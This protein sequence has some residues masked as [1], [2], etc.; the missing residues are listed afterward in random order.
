SLVRR[1][2]LSTAVVLTLGVGIGA[3]TLAFAIVDGVLLR[4]LPFPSPEELVDVSRVHPK[5]YGPNPTAAQAGN[6][7]ATPAATFFDWERMATTLSSMGAYAPTAATLA[8]ADKAPERIQGASVTA[9]LFTALGVR[10]TVGRHLVPSDD[11]PGAPP[12]VVLSHG[13]WLRRFGGD[14]SAVGRSINLDGT[15]V[16]VVGVMPAGF[17]FPDDDSDFWLEL[18]DA[19]KAEPARNAGYLHAVGRLAPGVSLER[20]RAEM[21]AI[22]DALG[23]THQDESRF[24]TVL[25]P[26][27]ELMVADARPGLLLLLGAAAIVLLVGCAN[28][29]NLL[30]ARAAERRRELAVHAALGAGRARLARLLLSESVMLA[31]VGGL[32]GIGLAFAGIG[33]MV[34]AFPMALP[35]AAGIHMDVRVLAVALTAS[36]GVGL[37]LGL[38]PVVRS[39]RL[40][41]NAVLRD[42]GRGATGGGRTS[43]THGLLVASEVALAVV[44]LSTSGLFV[45]SYL[46][47]GQ[48]DR[49]FDA[50]D[51]LT[52]RISMPDDRRGSD[53]AV[54]AFFAELEEDLAAIPAVR[55][56]A[57]AGQM[58][59]SGCCSS[60][61]ATVEGVE[62]NVQ[63]S[64][65]TGRVDES[66]FRAMRIPILAGRGFL[67]TDQ[68]GSA[69]V[70]VVSE[71]MARRFWRGEDPIG[72]RVR[73]D[74]DDQPTWREVVGVAGNVRYSF[75]APPA[76]EY[77]RPFAQ[78]P[79]PSRAIVLRTL[80]GA[81][82]VEAAVARAVHALEPDIAVEVRSLSRSMRADRQYR[83]VRVGSFVL[84]GLA[85]VATALAILGIYSVL[86][87][88]VLQRT[89][90][91][92]IRVSLGGSR[93]EI[94]L[95]VLRGGMVM[96]GVGVVIGL[97]L[98]LASSGFVRSALV[99]IEAVNVLTL[100]GIVLVVAVTA[101][102][103][104]LVPAWRAVHID[105][106]VAFRED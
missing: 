9:G 51:V 25:F 70:V 20:A 79:S 73:L 37:L 27:K 39:G 74:T 87:Y 76:A 16:T 80:P 13:L 95:H 41:L 38:L 33:P 102:M 6:V 30:L 84:V 98:A 43:R 45:E 89:R 86:A 91:I 67:P 65:Q 7:F 57:S 12:A 26:R 94:L 82:G 34:R 59:Y 17:S 35:R 101:V 97:G 22:T 21:A 2:G 44:L 19:S 68:E 99:G 66:Y 90:E 103:A 58:P 81:V 5:W 36:V 48:Q 32:G 29:G 31:V 54:R 24:K 104:S 50:R 53:D 61:P 55:V 83:W 1:A 49:G 3:T 105:P 92:G 52:L 85:L 18:D 10:A 40:D 15:P 11:Q 42:G 46:R 100:A 75:G 64:V 77:Y 72:R 47:T 71:A 62:G 96:T 8:E 23:G 88:G 4:P 60:P 78:D 56:V 69:P 106:L 14:P 63:G 28:V 93:R